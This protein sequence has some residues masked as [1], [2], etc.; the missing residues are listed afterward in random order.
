MS[1]E[2]LEAKVVKKTHDQM[3]EGDSVTRKRFADIQ[4]RQHNGRH[5]RCKFIPLPLGTSGVRN[6]IILASE[7]VSGDR[8]NLHGGGEKAHEQTVC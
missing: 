7:A 8:I 1:L 2:L 4:H 5:Q 3:V 6:S